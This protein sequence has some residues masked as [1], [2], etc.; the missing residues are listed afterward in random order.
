M[1]RIAKFF[2][3]WIESLKVFP[4]V[5]LCLLTLTVLVIGKTAD[6]FDVEGEI[7]VAVLFTLLIGIFVSL[8]NLY[9]PRKE[10]IG[11]K[12][13]SCIMQIAA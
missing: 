1:K 7:V 4:V 10:G 9:V 13:L 6:W 3:G 12:I 5:Y 2:A 8:G 11:S